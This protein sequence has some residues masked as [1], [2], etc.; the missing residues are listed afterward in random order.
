M[1][2][3]VLQNPNNNLSF[4]IARLTALRLGISS[5]L[6]LL[7]IYLSTTHTQIEPAAWMALTCYFPLLI[8]GLYHSR[9]GLQPI[10]LVIHLLFECQLLTLFLF[11]TGGASNPLISYLLILIVFSAYNL[12]RLW[13]WLITITCILDYSILTQFYQPL[14]LS[15]S[16]HHLANQAGP[17]SFLDW[18]LAGMWFTFLISAIAL[19]L[20][21]PTL[22][23]AA[24]IKRQQL[25]ELR[26]KQLKNEQLIG[27]ATLAAGTAHEMGTPLMTMEMILNDSI[28]HQL[29]LNKHDTELL[30]Q[31]VMICRQALQRLALAGR[32]IHKREEQINAN[33]WLAALLH[34]WRL[35]QPNAI[36]VN[37]GFEAQA[38]INKSPLLDQALLNLLDNASQAGSETI[39][40]SSEVID[41]Q[42]FLTIH[43]PDTLASN[44]LQQHHLF[45]SNKEHGIGLGLYLSNASIEQFDGQVH[46]AANRDGST[47]C[48]IRLPCTSNCE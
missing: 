29:V 7:L 15:L 22:T 1:L 5:L 20:L 40:L 28:E 38:L 2:N 23:Q 37:V 18:H 27:I 33:Q 34:R 9:Q 4:V 45:S 46:L 42:W 39:E 47:S 16:S 41:Q 11:F 6:L 30:H 3:S 25:A 31:Q 24:I 8:F 35:S 13:V 12:S 32:N 48:T 19:S 10:H 17:K 36:W 14:Q 26:E 44:N 43:Q 21:I